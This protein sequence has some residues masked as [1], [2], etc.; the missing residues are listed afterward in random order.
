MKTSNTTTAKPWMSELWTWADEYGI[1]EKD[2][3]RNEAHLLAITELEIC[4]DQITELPEGI[5][6]LH[7]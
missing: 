7:N 4:S 1:S 5:G 6:F 2:L 3:P